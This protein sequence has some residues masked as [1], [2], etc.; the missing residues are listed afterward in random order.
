M[1]IRTLIVVSGF[2]L[3]SVAL[4]DLPNGVA[5][6]E[7][8]TNS[9]L[10]WAHSTSVGNLSF[11][12]ATDPGFANIIGTQG[13]SVSDPTA[14]VK[15]G[16]SGL[17]PATRYYYRAVD[18]SG[19]I[20]SGTF[21]TAAPANQY[22]GFRLGVSGDWRGELAPYPSL[23]NAATANLDLWMSLGDTI[24]ADVASPAVPGGQAH[25]LS[26][27]RAKH[28]E[29]LSE[30][31]GLNVHRAI[32]Q[33]TTVMATID[34]HEVTNDFAGGAAISTDPRFGPASPN[35]IN[36][37]DLYNNGLQ[38][39]HE[40]HPIE[41]RTY[42]GTGDAR[43]DGR[44]DLYRTQK[45]GKDAAVFSL[46]AR[47]FRDQELPGVANP[48]DPLQVLNF[49]GASF[50]PGRTMLGNPQLD[51]LKGDLLNAQ[52]S[53]T[54]WKFVM[55]PEPIQNLG[56]LAASDRYE[57]YAAERADL[58]RYI[59]DNNIQ[60]VA[61][62]SADIHGT[63]VNN[64]TYSDGPFQPQIDS[65]AF[66]ITTGSGAYFAPFGPTVAGLAAQLNLPGSL[67][68]TTYL[69]LP[70]ANQEAY[71]QGLINAQLG[72]LGYD[73]LGLTGSNIQAQL[74]QGTWTATNSYGWTQFDIDP[75]T[76]QLRVTTYGIP[77]YNEAALLANPTL[78]ANL[79]PQIV[80]EFVVNPIPN[81]GVLGT[82]VL[83][84]LVMGR[85]RRN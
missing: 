12:V 4:A 5:T 84:G 48:A 20:S 26:E 45:F 34:D 51:R 68:L 70:A 46:D 28:N 71:I 11:Q 8:T 2:A 15:A 25:T 14:P 10:L 17:S 32:R 65:G 47:S 21:K 19:A 35:L 31:F 81:A 13:V 59:H 80:Q 74:L 52:Q 41:Q 24:Y 73:T 83:G 76:Q 56:A 58:L 40:Y 62:I 16:F 55:M 77:Y 7:T 18:A 67:P 82:L 63:L 75:I 29:T 53:G 36:T 37:S 33:S 44:P 39:F 54:T 69:S 60:N 22:S 64:V 78:I 57:G 61:F 6:G 9:S 85:R 23:R 3:S 49:I 66:E 72:G 50:T 30:R 43:V 1:S 38:A 42:S 79:Q 27:Y